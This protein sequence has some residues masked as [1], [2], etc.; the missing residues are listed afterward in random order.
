MLRLFAAICFTL[1][2]FDQAL[3]QQKEIDS[4]K[5]LLP[6][7]HDTGRIDC[8]ASIAEYYINN[9]FR[10]KDSILHYITLVY[11]ESKQINYKHGIAEA[12]ADKAWLAT[13]NYVNFSEG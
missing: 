11:Q 1:S 3:S 5:R 12:Y 10:E 13:S 7:L 4:L 2:T 9:A 8:L 6:P